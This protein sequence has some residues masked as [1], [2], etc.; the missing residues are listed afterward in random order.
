MNGQESVFIDRGRWLYRFNLD[1]GNIVIS[2]SRRGGQYLAAPEVWRC[3][4]ELGVTDA[5]IVTVD[6]VWL[7]F[8]EVGEGRHRWALAAR[9]TLAEAEDTVRHFLATLADA[10]TASARFQAGEA[11]ASTGSNGLVTV[12]ADRQRLRTPV[13]PVAQA[14]TADVEKALAQARA[15]RDNGGWELIYNKP[16]AHR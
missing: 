8:V 15:R 11:K 16:R 10:M 12:G 1:A 3:I 5:F 4:S 7:P 9:P 13:V 14:E 6:G 2:R